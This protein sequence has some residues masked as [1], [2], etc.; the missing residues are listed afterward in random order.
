M[1]KKFGKFLLFTAAAGTAAAVAYH[2][3]AKKDNTPAAAEEDDDYDNFSDDL[4]DDTPG[5]NYVSLAKEA[6]EKAVE[7]AGA[8]AETMVQKVG[9][10]MKNLS[11]IFSFS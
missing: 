11:D 2:F 1:A 6:S 3:L 4:E 8:V 10:A 7:K 5:R 9:D